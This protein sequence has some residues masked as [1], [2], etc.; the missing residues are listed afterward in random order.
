MVLLLLV[1]HHRHQ[2]RRSWSRLQIA[3]TQERCGLGI[4]CSGLSYARSKLP[5]G[6]VHTSDAGDQLLGGLDI[7]RL[8]HVRGRHLLGARG[9]QR[10]GLA[11]AR[12]RDTCGS[13]AGT[14]LSLR[15][16]LCLRGL[17]L[18]WGGRGE[19]TPPRQK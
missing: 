9:D 3:T 11:E 2:R 15:G 5:G 10:R 18:W 19:P 12:L 6:W 14:L 16:Q 17:L 4:R 7:A 1:S 13:G 8:R